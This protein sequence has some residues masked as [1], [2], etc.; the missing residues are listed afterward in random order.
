[1]TDVLPTSAG[2][3]SE[4][5]QENITRAKQE[6]AGPVPLIPD[7]PECNVVLPR[8]VTYQGARQ[9][10]AEV[11]ELTGVD[12][13]ALAK[14]KRPEDTF[15]AVV[16][17]GT[18]RIGPLMLEQVTLAERQHYLRN[19]LIGEREMLFV[20]IAQVTYGDERTY[21]VTCPAC[22]RDQDLHVKLS[23]DFKPREVSSEMGDLVF[24]TSKGLKLEYRLATGGDQLEVLGK[25]GV[26]AAEMN[27]ILLSQCILSVD[28]AMVVDPINFARSLPIRDRQGML[29]ELVERQ[30]NVEM[31]VKYDCFGCGE[32]Q[33]ISFG[34]LDLFRA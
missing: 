23:E 5:L 32:G 11:R 20:A 19:L 24:V 22:Q 14:I 15:D 3:V 28:G 13:E 4:D 6:M 33:Q 27:T 2:Q 31:T 30:P 16:T 10:E 17:R 25:D 1:M 9:R 18:V 21:P 7:A 8:G 12:E 26:T 34:W 29:T